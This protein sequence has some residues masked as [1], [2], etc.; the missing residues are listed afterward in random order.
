[1]I[2]FDPPW[3]PEAARYAKV[4]PAPILYTKN[5]GVVMMWRSKCPAGSSLR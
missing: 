1:L 2:H 3:H 4:R 5:E